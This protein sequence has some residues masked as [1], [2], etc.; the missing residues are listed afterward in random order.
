MQADPRRLQGVPHSLVPGLGLGLV[1][2]VGEHPL[3]PQLPGQGGNDLSRATVAQDQ[4]APLG[5]QGLVQVHDAAVNKLHPP[6]LGMGQGRQNVLIEKK[7]TPDLAGT[8][9]GGV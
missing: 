5:G 3:D 1:I 7:N 8:G 2:P 9:E 4:P 6:I